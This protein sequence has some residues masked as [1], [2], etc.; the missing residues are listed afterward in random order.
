MDEAARTALRSQIT[1]EGYI[2]IPEH[3][4]GADIVEIANQLGT[5]LTPWE[6]GLVQTLTP[7]EDAAPNT[8]SGNFG[9]GRFPFH[10]DLAHWRWPPRYL[11]LRCL[12]GYRDVPT[13]LIDGRSLIDAISRDV[14]ARAIFRPRRPRDGSVALFRLFEPAAQGADLLRWDEIF[15]RPASR[16]GEIANAEI[17]EWLA[18]SAPSSIALIRTGDTLIIDNWRMLHA[19]SPIPPGREDRSIQRVYLGGLN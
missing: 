16:V 13:S 17:R 2:L 4:P 12:T 10:T 18:T 19:R 6:G 14:L 15:L 5:P 9:L 8:Y 11:L 3:R 1:Q 7:R